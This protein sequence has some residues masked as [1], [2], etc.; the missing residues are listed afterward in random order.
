MS[1][2]L[3]NLLNFFRCSPP[4]SGAVSSFGVHVGNIVELCSKKQMHWVAASRLVA[5]WAVVADHHAFRD[6][7]E[8]EFPGNSVRSK[9]LVVDANS[10]ISLFCAAG[11]EPAFSAFDGYF[12]PEA[13]SDRFVAPV[14]YPGHEAFASA[15]EVAFGHT[16]PAWTG[17]FLVAPTAVASDYFAD[18]LRHDEPLYGSL[19]IG[20]SSDTHPAIRPLFDSPDYRTRR[21][22]FRS[23]PVC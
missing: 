4:V 19:W 20:R 9:N 21:A 6:S 5:S 17:E 2:F 3:T 22:D 23:S 13:I 10:A 1:R 8:N 18:L 14:F 16:G 11:P 7:S 12:V 15:T